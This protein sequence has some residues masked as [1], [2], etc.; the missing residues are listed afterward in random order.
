VVAVLVA[1]LADEQVALLLP[2][3]GEI[4]AGEGEGK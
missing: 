4:R 2:F 3:L 1:H